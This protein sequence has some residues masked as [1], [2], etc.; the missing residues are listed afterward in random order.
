MILV[1]MGTSE[2]RF[3]RLANQLKRLESSYEFLVQQG[4]NEYELK[5][6]TFEFCDRA[7]VEKLIVRADLVVTQAGIGSILDC[8]KHNKRFVMVARL[9]KFNEHNTSQVKSALYF[10][11]TYGVSFCDELED[12]G[13]YIE[14][15]YRRVPNTAGVS[16][17]DIL[18]SE[19]IKLHLQY[20]L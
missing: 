13:Q 3:D 11:D 4:K 15:E 1:L 14:L 19:L 5:S 10:R 17:Q 2:Q 8:L 12:L 6:D 16:N 9:P 18:A 7:E 20:E